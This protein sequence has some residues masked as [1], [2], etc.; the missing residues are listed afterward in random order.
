MM[1]GAVITI[2]VN[3]NN[4]VRNVKKDIHQL[5]QYP[6]NRQ[7]LVFNGRRL[8]DHCRLSDYNI[9]NGTTLH[10]VQRLRA[11]NPH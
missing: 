6:P 4:Y 10:L 9:R 1:D 7:R 2:A 8:E 5:Y 3:P 11:W